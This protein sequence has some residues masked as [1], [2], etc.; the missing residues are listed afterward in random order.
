MELPSGTNGILGAISSH[1]PEYLRFHGGSDDSTTEANLAL[2]G[3]LNGSPLTPNEIS[4]IIIEGVR[5]LERSRIDSTTAALNT[6]RDDLRVAV[7]SITESLSVHGQRVTNDMST[8]R[9]GFT[10]HVSQ[11]V[12]GLETRLAHA[13]TGVPERVK[14]EI[15]PLLMSEVERF[16]IE[17]T[18]AAAV[19][20]DPHAAGTP[21]AILSAAVRQE[22]ASGLTQV[23]NRITALTERLGVDEARAQERSKSAA[24]GFDFE[25]LLE[26]SL[27]RFAVREKLVVTATGKT[28]GLI[29]RC[30]KGDFVISDRGTPLVVVEAKDRNPQLS[31]SKIH[32][33]LDETQKNRD[34]PIAVWTV[35]GRDQNRDELLTELT[36]ARWVVAY[37]EDSESVFHALLSV[38][39]AKAKAALSRTDGDTETARKKVHDALQSAS[40]LSSVQNMATGVVRSAEALSDKVRAIR[41]RVVGHLTEAAAA[42]KSEAGDDAEVDSD[43][44]PMN[45]GPSD[46]LH[47]KEKA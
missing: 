29:P 22:V 31:L 26:G 24:K 30:L 13:T 38:S 47:P 44:A 7:G 40:D 10:E 34:T 41:E 27:E 23:D 36:D 45:L 43:V 18:R 20:L 14:Q 11:L 15:S 21:G 37:E 42:L 28:A 19:A 46:F 6:A 8:A 32:E 33:E 39:V 3:Y 2:H 35:N 12:S 4:R 16:R 5:S 17:L 9:S 1:A 25:D